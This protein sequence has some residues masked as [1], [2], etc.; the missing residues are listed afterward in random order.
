M[1]EAGEVRVPQFR[2]RLAGR[3]DRALDGE[4]PRLPDDR[5]EVG[6]VDVLHHEAWRQPGRPGD[7][8][9]PV[10]A[11]LAEPTDIKTFAFATDPRSPT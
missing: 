9:T 3:L 8:P 6:A 10:A 11:K 7:K 2:S 5:M 4:R 1:H